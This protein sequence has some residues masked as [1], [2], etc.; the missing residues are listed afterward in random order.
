MRHQTTMG[1]ILQG[2]NIFPGSKDVTFR[3][4]S[5]DPMF[6]LSTDSALLTDIFRK[7]AQCNK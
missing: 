4:Y 6:I 5:I 7:Y 3:Q 1:Y 2:L